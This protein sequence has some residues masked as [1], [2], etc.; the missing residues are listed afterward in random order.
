[1]Q[2]IFFIL[3]KWM[4]CEKKLLGLMIAFTYT[5]SFASEE[6]CSKLMFI[7]NQISDERVNVVD[8]EGY[9]WL[10][11]D[12]KNKLKKRKNQERSLENI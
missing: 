4:E 11:L 9:K 6:N 12:E 7:Q 10:T 1:M 8:Y 2:L 3:K 5:S